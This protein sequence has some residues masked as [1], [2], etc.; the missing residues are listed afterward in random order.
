MKVGVTV[1]VRLGVEVGTIKA[2]VMKP[3]PV[4]AGV[5][6][7]P[8]GSCATALLFSNGYEPGGVP[9]KMSNAQEY[10]SPSGIGELLIGGPWTNTR[11]VVVVEVVATTLATRVFPRAGLTAQFAGSRLRAL[12]L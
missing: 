11:T 1:G 8:V 7:A 5:T 2:A 3:S 12:W 6:M 4:V 10:R 9:G